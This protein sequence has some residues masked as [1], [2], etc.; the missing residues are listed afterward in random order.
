MV[1]TQGRAPTPL[2]LATG[3]MDQHRPI[4][5]PAS[6]IETGSHSHLWMRAVS[7]AGLHRTLKAVGDAPGGLRAKEINNL[8]LEQ[9]V[10]LTPANPHPKPTT[11][12][13]YRTTLVRLNAL[14]RKDRKL[15][16]NTANPSVC[17]LLREPAP[18]NGEQT[19]TDAAKEHFAA[20]VL[21]IEDCRMLFF[22][23]FMSS[24]RSCSSVSEFRETG[25]PVS[26]VRTRGPLGAEVLF[27]NT[28][29]GR[30]TRLASSVG[31]SSILYGVRYWARDELELIDEYS[32]PADDA[33]IMFP[34]LHR[35][36]A[37]SEGLQSPAMQ[38]VQFLLDRRTAEEWTL[39]SISDLIIDYC[40]TH[41]QPRTSLFGAIDWLR[42]EWPFHTV[43]IPTSRAMATFAATSPQ[44]EDL[45]LRRYYKSPQGPYISHIR[46]HENVTCDTTDVTR[47]HVY[48]ASE[49]RA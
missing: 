43:L 28:V 4:M 21:G 47:H 23:L 8:V 46:V 6:N 31:V 17:A 27:E 36:S 19:L 7:F 30:T 11:L 39:Y 25:V 1:S 40:Q 26:W 13:H 48:H 45:A 29:N 18:D 10:V 15:I 9:K 34:V 32:R 49:A 33:T 22:D 42:R 44:R 37:A 2:D 24:G 20:L 12:Y 38:A 14:I 3:R 5:E 41:R 16:A 35:E